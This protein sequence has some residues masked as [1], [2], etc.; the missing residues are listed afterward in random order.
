MGRERALSLR[1]KLVIFTTLL[2]FITYSCSAVFIY[3]VFENVKDLL[4]ISEPVFVLL[5]L[6]L[7]VIWSGILAFFASGFITKPLIKLKKAA[8]EAAEGNLQQEINVPKSMDEIGLLTVAFNKMMNNLKEVIGNIDSNA[9][10]TNETVHDLKNVATRSAQQSGL[11][12]Q[13]VTQ[14][15]A[16]AES[17][18]TSMQQMVEAVET[19]TA[20]ATKV[21]EKATT[22]K[23][24]SSTMIK[25]LENGKEVI[26]KLIVGVQDLAESQEASLDDVDRLAKKAV[27]VGDVISMVGGISEQT[28]LLALN[29]SIEAARAG[30]H[31][32]GFA[33]VADEVRQLA[34][35]SSQAVQNIA[36]LINDMQMDV[37][38]VVEKMTQQVTKTREEA[39][40]GKQTTAALQHM[41]QSIHEVVTTIEDISELVAKQLGEIQSTVEQAQEVSAIAQQT[42][43]GTQ[44]MSA[45]IQEQTAV[46]E[47]LEELAIS[48]EDQAERLRKHIKRFTLAS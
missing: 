31:G 12:E 28:N 48:L 24:R 9:G 14:I 29:A 38:Q 42:S 45:S 2:A 18:S 16:G 35:Q 11:I 36:E 15:A 41:S 7:G 47:H 44:Q 8:S 40:N 25:E 4:N 3:F 6:L 1:V 33:V 37:R 23:N 17:S 10:K 34:D 32:K 22:S 5:T 26:H 13:T 20:L 27:Q 39:R 30:E 21:Q 46:T 19:S 43:A